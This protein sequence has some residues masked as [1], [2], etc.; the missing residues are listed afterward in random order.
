[1]WI[2][3]FLPAWSFHILLLASIGGLV[4]SQFFKFVPFISTYSLPIQIISTLVL[5]LSIY[6]QG[7]LAEQA[8]WEAKVKA[9]EAKVAIAEEQSKTANA[10]LE[11]ALAQKTQIVKEV[12][13]VIKDRIVKEAAKIDST[14]VVQPQ[15]IEILNQAAGK[16]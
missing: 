1:M 9:L 5:A 13:V 11:T 16:K 4:A 14:C 6:V 7:G 3:D 15:V 8:V 10:K 12:Q 2:I